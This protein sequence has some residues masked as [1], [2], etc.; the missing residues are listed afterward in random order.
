LQQVGSELKAL[1]ADYLEGL[2]AEPTQHIGVELS[3]IDVFPHMNAFGSDVPLISQNEMFG[4]DGATQVSWA[5]GYGGVVSCNHMFG[6]AGSAFSD[7]ERAEEVEDQIELLTAESAFGCD[8]IEIGYR[9]RGGLLE[10]FLAVWDALSAE[11]IWI[12]GLGTSDLHDTLD[13]AETLNNFVTWVPSASASESDISW[14]LVRG[15]AWFGDPTFFTEAHVDVRFQAPDVQAT[16]GQVAAG[17]LGTQTVEFAISP[18]EAGWVVRL[19]GNGAELVPEWTI[20]EAG[21]F[22]VSETVE[23]QTETA[24]RFEVWSSDGEAVLFTNPIYFVDAERD[25]PMERAPTP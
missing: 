8:L 19:I 25:V 16:M 2:K 22:E 13:Y 24:V 10:D 20:A 15:M 7:D 1:Q 14:S 3:R 12:T 11:R 6:M 5:Q 23:L 21:T 4:W 17:G 18:V 9:E